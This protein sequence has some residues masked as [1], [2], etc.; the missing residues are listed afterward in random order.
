VFLPGAPAEATGGER[1]TREQHDVSIDRRFLL[2]ALIS[3]AL[4][5]SSLQGSMVSVAL[6]DMIEDLHAPLRWVGWVMTVYTLAQAVSMPIVGK[7]SDELGRRT[8]F[9]GGV[10]L[11]GVASPGAALAPNVYVLIVMRGIQGLAGGSLLP[12]AYGVVGDV[13]L[14]DRARAIGM[15]SSVFPI[16]SIIG[17]LAGGVIVDQFG[18]RWTFAIAVLPVL[19][20]V[21]LAYRW[22]PA[23]KTRDTK[24]LDMPGVLSLSV[25][26]LAIVYALTELSQR[27]VAPNML[28]VAV[29]LAIGLVAA[30]AFVRREAT[31]ADPLVEMRLLKQK[32]FAYVNALNFLYGAGIFGLFTFI[33]LYAES[34]YGFSSS[35]AG[36]LITPRAVMMIIASSLAAYF[37]P[38]TGYRRP[39]IVGLVMMSVSTVVLSLGLHDPVLLGLRVPSAIYLA[40][41]VGVSGLAFGIAG[42]AA[43]NAAIELAPDRIAAITGLRGMFRSLGGT[44]GTAMIILVASRAESEGAGLEQAFVGIA[45]VNL[46]AV[47]FVFGTPDRVGDRSQTAG[48]GAAVVRREP[49]R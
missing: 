30:V 38:R 29:F 44:L 25:G 46:L 23:A 19:L 34:A 42:P 2:F 41:I 49:A 11:F 39:I 15:I 21:A 8:V 24:P 32:E 10:V 37:L 3:G 47:A 48:G 31:A 14:E 43:N 45:V 6:P 22:M 5:I 16:G 7:L 40:T 26:V 33:P 17:P 36:A 28:V 20:I 18:W 9:V 13:F 35:A 27:Q 4:L 12:S 1:G